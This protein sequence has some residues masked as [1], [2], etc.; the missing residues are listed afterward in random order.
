MVISSVFAEDYDEAIDSLKMETD[1]NEVILARAEAL[2][3]MVDAKLRAPL[4][5]TLGP[6]SFQ[7][8]LNQGGV[9]SAAKVSYDFTKATAKKPL[10]GPKLSRIGQSQPKVL[11]WMDFF[12]FGGLSKR[13]PFCR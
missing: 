13:R 6:D 9:L 10:E 1:I 12:D 5:I 8:L 3:I 11:G 2:V 7:R 4:Q